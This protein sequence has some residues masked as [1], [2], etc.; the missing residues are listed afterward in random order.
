MG[1]EDGSGLEKSFFELELKQ[2]NEG[3]PKSR[4]SLAGLLKEARPSYSNLAGEVISMDSQQI[5][6]LSTFV[7]EDKRG[8]VLLPFLIIKEA[9]TRK[10]EYTI[11]GNEDEIKTINMVL[12][13]DP[14]NRILYR[15]EILLLLKKY[16]SL[17][18][19]GYRFTNT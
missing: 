14:K 12:K 13:R 2:L 5:S 4:K 10:G 18:V 11:Q 19:F 15:P 7:R 16:D 8:D 9:G 3:L 6:D 17:I 1:A